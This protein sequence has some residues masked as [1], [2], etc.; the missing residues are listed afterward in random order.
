[1]ITVYHIPLVG[2]LR[3]TQGTPH[4]FNV[5]HSCAGCPSRHSRNLQRRHVHADVGPGLADVGVLQSVS[6]TDGRPGSQ[7]VRSR[8]EPQMEQRRRRYREG[9]EERE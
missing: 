4:A 2:V 7:L 1:M 3:M 6:M 8:V 5:L 9:L